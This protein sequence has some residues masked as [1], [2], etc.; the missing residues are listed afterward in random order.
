[1]RKASANAGLSGLRSV[2]ATVSSVYDVFVYW[3]RVARTFSASIGST[4][5]PM[6]MAMTGGYGD[7]SLF[8][9]GLAGWDGEVEL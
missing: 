3:D 9:E 6:S 4:G 1:M 2:T 5:S 7:A 8:E